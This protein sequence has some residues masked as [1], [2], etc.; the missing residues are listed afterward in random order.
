MFLHDPRLI[1]HSAHSI[2]RLKNKEDNVVD[3]FFWPLASND[4]TTIHDKKA[5]HNFRPYNI[6]APKVDQF[7]MHDQALYSIW[8]HYVEFCR[9]TAKE[10]K[11]FG[12][13][14][15][16]AP[17]DTPMNVFTQTQR[18]PV[19]QLLSSSEGC[20]ITREQFQLASRG[21]YHSLTPLLCSN[22]LNFLFSCF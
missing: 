4:P 14:P 22:V 21:K 10:A 15:K 17:Q 7:K 3:S 6:P 20:P 8:M 2:S 19:F 9:F 13:A 18:L 5:N 11:S 12:N 16:L 1:C